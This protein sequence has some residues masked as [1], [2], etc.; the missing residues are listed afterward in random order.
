VRK[1]GD[2]VPRGL[3]EFLKSISPSEI[4]F[5]GH[6]LGCRVVLET[7]SWLLAPQ[8]IVLS[9]FILMAGA[10]PIH[11]LVPTEKLRRAATVARKRYCLYSW[12]DLVL[13]VPF[14]PGQILAGEPSPYLLPIATG[15]TGAPKG[16]YDA[17]CSTWLGHGGYW[18][19]GVF[20]G[21][22]PYADMLAGSFPITLN[23]KITETGIIQVRDTRKSRAVPSRT[24]P[25]R[26]VP[27][28][29]WLGEA[30]GP[31]SRS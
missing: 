16:F 1:A 10:V 22:G 20:E 21:P 17:R 13:S 9:G 12:I 27:G 3:A 7:I 23:R 4:F 31:D 30:Y 26:A 25:S 19:R 29:N 18:K 14:G 28:N 8:K 15:L 24:L 2:W 11:M 6:S 5:I